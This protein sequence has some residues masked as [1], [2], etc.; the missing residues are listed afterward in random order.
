MNI[1]YLYIYIILKYIYVYMYI[2][3]KIYTLI[4]PFAVHLI[5]L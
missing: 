5:L 2:I 4:L 3:L 1:S